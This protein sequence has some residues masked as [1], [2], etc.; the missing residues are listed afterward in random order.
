MTRRLIQLSFL[1]IFL[2]SQTM[3]HIAFA[4]P[5][6]WTE[7][8]IGKVAVRANKAAT[9]KKWS[10][11]I[12]YGEQ[13]LSASEA[14]YGQNHRSYINRLKTLNRHYDKSG[15]LAK[16][17]ERV[18]LAYELS[19]KHYKA[20]HVA[21]RVS[22]LLYYKLLVSQKNYEAAT[23]LVLENIAI[24]TDSQDDR[25]KK[26]HYLGQLHG[27]YGIT[28]QLAMQEETL[29]MHLAL[30]QRLM[31]SALEDSI[32]IIMNLGKTY[33]LQSKKLAFNTL[34][35]TYALKYKC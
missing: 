27:L 2:F 3:T 11:A 16:I 8:E 23:P 21:A 4:E 7:E 33:C 32:S 5:T 26:L 15:H 19:K 25:F 1:I 22:H 13:V 10:R 12:R 18:K 35:Q 34:M 20:G 14:L 31:G 17:P 29:E 28:N 6:G 30:N 24:L 9:R